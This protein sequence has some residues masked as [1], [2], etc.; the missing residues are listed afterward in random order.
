MEHHEVPDFYGVYLL[1]SQTKPRSLY[2]GSTPDPIRRLRQHNGEINSG[3]WRTKRNGYRPWKMIVIISGF[4]SRISALQFEHAFQHAYQTRHIS[5]KLTTKSQHCGSSLHYKL[6]N[7]RLLLGCNYFKPLNL[8]VNIFCPD[9]QKVWDQNK[10]QI[11]VDNKVRVWEDFYEFGQH[12]ND[13]YRLGQQILH[14]KS[15]LV[16]VHRCWCCSEEIDMLDKDDIDGNN[17]LSDK[18]DLVAGEDSRS[19]IPLV[20]SC[21]NCDKIF[22]LSCLTEALLPICISC[23]LCQTTLNWFKLVMIATKLR[24][25]FYN[26]S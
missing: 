2:I 19:R 3:A 18:D 24:I 22:H 7:L 10:H 1:R 21:F 16:S 6:G 12:V 14:L 15:E 17:L 26:S 4:P 25:H 8:E 13:F 11:S 9:L 20:T 5:N 23:P